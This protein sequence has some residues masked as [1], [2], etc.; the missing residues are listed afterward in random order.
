MSTLHLDA[1][2]LYTDLLAGVR[3]LMKPD[4]VLVGIW[5]CRAS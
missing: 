3:S 1:E 4:T 2:A 5:S